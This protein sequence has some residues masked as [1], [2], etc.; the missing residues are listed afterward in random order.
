[1]KI[2]LIFENWNKFINED[3]GSGK[4]NLYHFSKSN[5]PEMVLDPGRSLTARN[6]WSKREYNISSVPRVFF[7]TDL[8]N[9][10]NMVSKGSSLYTASVSSSDIYDLTED[11][12]GLLK[13]SIGQYSASPDMDKVLKSLS[14]LDVPGK[15][16]DPTTFRQLRP[17]APLFKGAFYFINNGTTPIVVWFEKIQ[18]AQID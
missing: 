9:T 10:E 2:K 12:E 3:L 1:M 7:Y 11:P 18:V 5:Q 14:G 16:S 15:Y 17:N 8:D 13:K 6:S 4:I